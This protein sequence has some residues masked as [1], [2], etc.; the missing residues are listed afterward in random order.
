MLVERFLKKVQPDPVSECLL[1][2]GARQSRGYGAIRAQGRVELAHRVSWRL[3]RA[4]V[5]PPEM[6]LDHT[7]RVKR[8]VNPYHL[9]PRGRTEHGQLASWDRYYAGWDPLTYAL[10][11]GAYHEST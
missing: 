6:T 8:C 5:L 7:C 9:V 10:L 11:N 4:E 3:F 2:M 1:W